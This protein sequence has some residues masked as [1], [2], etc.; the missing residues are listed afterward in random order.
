MT[1]RTSLDEILAIAYGE[2]MVEQGVVLTEMWVRVR[3]PDGSLIVGSR[4]PVLIQ[5]DILA[6]LS[7]FEAELMA[8][9]EEAGAT[10]QVLSPTSRALPAW[11]A[12]PALSNPK[13]NNYF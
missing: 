13:A 3:Q 5:H 1:D 7:P 12:G 9:F 2:I 4:D 6:G 11:D 10:L 8:K